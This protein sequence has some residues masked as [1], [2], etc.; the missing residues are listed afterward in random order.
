VKHATKIA[1]RLRAQIAK[2]SGD[3]CLGLCIPAQRF[4]A[5][6]VYGIQ[7]AQSVLL[8]EVG[9]TLEEP[10]ALKKTHE[11]LS[12]NLMRPELEGLLQRNVLRLAA[13]RI[14]NDTLLI[15]DPSDL[16]KKYAK[17][18][19]YL[20]TVRD[21]SAHDLANGYWTLHV[22]GAQLDSQAI[23]PLY[24]R[25]WSCQAPGFVSENEE[26]L[27][28]VDAVQAHAGRRGIWVI[29]RGGDRINLFGPLLDRGAR[30][31]VRLI[32]NRDVLYKGQRMLAAHAAAHCR[33]PYRHV[34]TRMQDGQEKTFELRF[35]YCTVR[36][37]GREEPLSLLVIHGFGQQPLMLLTNVQ[38]SNSFRS[39]WRMVRRYLKRWAIEDTIRYIKTCYELEDVRVL[40]YQS[41]RNLMVLLLAVM[42]F[43]ACVLDTHA[44][45]RVMARYVERAAKRVFGIP[46]FKYYALADGLRAL[47]ARSP[48]FVRPR[49]H[50]N[51]SPQLHLFPPGP[52]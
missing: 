4:V 3:L 24:Q 23:V 47:F 22:I 6:M 26:I 2:F 37:P 44:R 1:Q 13:G 8:T 17:K 41:L 38:L 27:R 42:Y 21:G 18:M 11:R 9:R 45:L 43:A 15:I 33:C 39:L 29:D 51:T 19:E 36:L 32:G 7:A 34:V 25:L 14:E 30:F 48:G 31:L 50:K 20:G 16:A 10:I 12:R 49:I 35:G 40:T 28:A 46:D 52:T 5:E